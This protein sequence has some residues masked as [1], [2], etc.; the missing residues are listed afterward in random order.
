MGRRSPTPETGVLETPWPACGHVGILMPYQLKLGI[1][2]DNPDSSFSWKG[3]DPV[4]LGP[5]SA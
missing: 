1:A 3:E 2:S 5:P 4:S